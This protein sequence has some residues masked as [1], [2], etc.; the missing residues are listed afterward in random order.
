MGAEQLPAL[1]VKP[2][3]FLQQGRAASWGRVTER[4][5]WHDM[6][7]WRKAAPARNHSILCYQV[8]VKPAASSLSQP[9]QQHLPAAWRRAGGRFPCS[10]GPRTPWPRPS[11][12]TACSAAGAPAGFL[13]VPW[14]AH[15]GPRAARG[16]RCGARQGWRGVHMSGLIC[17]LHGNI[18]ALHTCKPTVQGRGLQSNAYLRGLDAERPAS[19]GRPCVEQ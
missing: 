1:A 18:T 19:I 10:C 13:Q 12:R 11:G 3:A 17:G 7:H 8:P 9:S 16:V 6:Q 15:A 2:G 14:P 4:Q 5:L